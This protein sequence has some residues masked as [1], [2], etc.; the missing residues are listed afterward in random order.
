MN[1]S[2]KNLNIKELKDL[3]KYFSVQKMNS[4]AVLIY[5][6][7]IP[8]MGILLIN[9][10]INLKKKNRANV[11]V[12]PGTILGVANLYYNQPS[13]YACEVKK[14]SEVILISKSDLIQSITNRKSLL[15]SFFA[16]CIL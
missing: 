1:L 4:E 2:C 16:T 12:R 8:N 15:H 7:Q 11:K 6:S 14:N 3:R 9:G 10:E 5:E 13:N